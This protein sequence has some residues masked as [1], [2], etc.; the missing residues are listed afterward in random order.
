MDSSAEKSQV[1]CEYDDPSLDYAL[2][3]VN[4]SQL[5][6]D[7]SV[8][9]AMDIEEGGEED[10][11]LIELDHSTYS[12]FL[13]ELLAREMPVTEGELETFEQG[14]VQVLTPR[15]DREEDHQNSVYITFG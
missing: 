10:G 15:L 13:D 9:S 2:V 6:E 4:D 14:M 1:A 3:E 8:D 11:S 7:E 5:N 12:D